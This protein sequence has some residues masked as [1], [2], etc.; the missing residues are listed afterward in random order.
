MREG[1]GGT[2][3]NTLRQAEGALAE[4]PG[5]VFGGGSLRNSW[6]NGD[7]WDLIRTNDQM[8]LE[9]PCIQMAGKL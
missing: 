6:R 7:D 1:A 9:A 3:L 5:A 2:N 4:M 8:P